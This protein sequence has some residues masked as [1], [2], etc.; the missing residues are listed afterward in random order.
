VAKSKPDKT[1]EPGASG[2]DSS[3]ADATES[4]RPAHR[5]D[6]RVRGDRAAVHDRRGPKGRDDA[7][8]WYPWLGIKRLLRDIAG[9]SA[10][11][12]TL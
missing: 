1:R 6:W 9:G 4:R 2:C 10:W 5:R 12:P 8:L 7:R 3:P 11:E